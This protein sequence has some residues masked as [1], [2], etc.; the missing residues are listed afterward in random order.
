MALVNAG[1]LSSNGEAFLLVVVSNAA[2]ATF[3]APLQSP[4]WKRLLGRCWD[5]I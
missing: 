3:L 1:K 4:P 5:L 2:Q